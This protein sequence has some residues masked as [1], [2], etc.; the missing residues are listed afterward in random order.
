MGAFN[1]GSFADIGIA[2][3]QLFGMLV[4][5]ILIGGWIGYSIG[6]WLANRRP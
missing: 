4:V 3:E 1:G 5:G 6:E 2:L